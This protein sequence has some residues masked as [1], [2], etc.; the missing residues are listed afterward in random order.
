MSVLIAGGG[1]Q[2]GQVVGKSDSIGGYVADRPIPSHDV[3]A[4]VYHAFGIKPT[5]RVEDVGGT[6]RNVLL[7][8]EPIHELF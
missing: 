2:G 4:S 7:K 5:D 1:V 6:P 8:G 3:V